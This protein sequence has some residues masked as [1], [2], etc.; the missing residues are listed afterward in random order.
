MRLVVSPRYAWAIRIF[1]LPWILTT[2]RFPRARAPREVVPSDHETAS[3]SR[4]AARARLTRAAREASDALRRADASPSAPKMTHAY[5]GPLSPHT[6][7]R[8]LTAHTRHHARG[9]MR[10]SK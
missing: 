1:I 4:E 6:T 2:T 9:L 8:L 10:K 5:F 7:L 3:L